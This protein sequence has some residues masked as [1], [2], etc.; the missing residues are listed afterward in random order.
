[1]KFIIKFL[2]F[3]EDSTLVSLITALL[4]LSVTQII[5]RNLGIAGFMWADTALRVA[6]LWLAIFGAMRASRM[7]NH[8]AMDLVSHYASLPI[9]KFLHRTVSLACAGICAVAAFYC[10]DFVFDEYTMGDIA[11]L[12]I[13]VW[14]TESIIPFGLSVIALRFFIQIFFFIPPSAEES[15]TN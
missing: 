10:W 14:F 13:P 11:F 7:R 12:N 15:P 2:H 3:L 9:Q 1:M 5:L 6:V 8:I 4:L